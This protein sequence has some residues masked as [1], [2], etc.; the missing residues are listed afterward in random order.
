MPGIDLNEREGAILRAVVECHVRTA[1][2]VSSSVVAR[3]SGVKLSSATIRNV[4][5]SLE[6]RGLILQPH[7]SAGRV[8]TDMGYRYFVDNLMEPARL[9]ESE[10]AT[11]AEELSRL[12]HCDLA[13]LLA[14]VSHMVSELS[15]ELA[16]AVAPSGTEQLLRRV[17][18]V[19]VASGA[20][21]AVAT[22][23]SG[24]PRTAVLTTG[25]E[26]NDEDLAAANDLLQ[27]WLAGTAPTDAPELVNDRVAESSPPPGEGLRG[28][29]ESTAA[30]LGSGGSERIHYD[31]ARYIF[32]HPELSSDVAALG[33]IFDSEES[34]ADVVRGSNDP[35]RVVVVIGAENS[36]SGMKKMSLVAGT[37]RI[38]GAVARMGVIGPTRMRYPRLVGLVDHFSR[39]LDELF[40]G[41]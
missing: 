27:K 6:E 23:D 31:G 28:L 11:I 1:R 5:R 16:V 7:T 37:Y 18:L 13:T 15:K 10:L 14:G 40:S 9:S 36:R 33:E 17:A 20:L 39:V 30:F 22:H 41:S 38:G 8:P 3:D 12:A 24:P 32:R 29:L 34:L 2:P 35:S 21:L 25:R 4:M 19:R 26:V